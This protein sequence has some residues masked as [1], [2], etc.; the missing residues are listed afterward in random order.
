[1]ISSSEAASASTH[2][3]VFCFFLSF[4]PLRCF[5]LGPEVLDVLAVLAVLDVLDVLELVLQAVLRPLNLNC[6]F[7]FP[8]EGAKGKK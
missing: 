8:I 1:M 3:D 2:T 4:F 7:S 5:S 6:I